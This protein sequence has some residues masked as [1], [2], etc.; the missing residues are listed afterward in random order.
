MNINF[1]VLADFAST[2]GNKLNVMGIWDQVNP[3]TFP[4]QVLGPFLVMK[5]EADTTEAGQERRLSVVLVNADGQTMISAEQQL[6]IPAPPRPGANPNGNIIIQIPVL[7][8]PAAGDY[9]FSILV[10]D[11][12]KADARLTVNAPATGDTGDAE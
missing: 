10:D 8:F 1:A 6:V 11:D 4:A 9:K 7:Q 5:F 3:G 12:H 2:S